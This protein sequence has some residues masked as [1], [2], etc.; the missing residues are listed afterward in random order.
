MIEKGQK[1]VSKEDL[2]HG[3]E[4]EL[5]VESATGYW[6]HVISHNKKLG[7]KR[8]IRI[9][10][11][12]LASSAYKLVTEQATAA[13]GLLLVALL[14]GCAT[15]PAARKVVSCQSAPQWYA[16]NAQGHPTHGIYVCFADDGVLVYQ[17][18][19]LSL[20]ELAALMPPA[21]KPAPKPIAKPAEKK[22]SVITGGNSNAVVGTPSLSK[23]EELAAAKAKLA[24]L[25]EK[26]A[27]LDA[28]E[29][30][31]RVKMEQKRLAD[32]EAATAALAA[33]GAN[34]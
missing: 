21:P 15:A 9:A 5:E 19:A 18:R 25:E 31:E 28:F 6:A 23:A 22:Y 12:R 24:E 27:K 4:R 14:T 16:S 1:Y 17:A 7:T 30:K 26:A 10:V 20:D 29:K 8:R 32:Q 3:R 13:V 34:K 11:A 33:P 2:N